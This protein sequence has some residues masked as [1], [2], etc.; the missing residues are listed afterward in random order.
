[1]D[2]LNASDII[3]TDK[4]FETLTSFMATYLVK[5]IIPFALAAPEPDSL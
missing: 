1:M 2:G 5:F 3:L 4:A